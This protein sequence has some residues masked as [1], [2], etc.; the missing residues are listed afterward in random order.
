MTPDRIRPPSS[1][2]RFALGCALALSAGVGFGQEPP[3]GQSA[4]ETLTVPAREEETGRRPERRLETDRDSF[5]PSVPT[6]GRGRLILE[7]AYS[8]LDNRRGPETH[9]FPELLLRL[10]VAERIEL[11]LGWN[12]EIGG[13]GTWPEGAEDLPREQRITYGLKAAVTEQDRWVPES[14]VLL[15][16]FTPI[17]GESTATVFAV[18]YVLGWEVA[19]RWRFDSAVRYFTDSE[20]GDRF[21][22]WAP[23]AVLRVPVGERWNVHA[24][25]FGQFA[26]DRRENFARH[27]VS[28]G[29]SCLVT[30]D[31][32]LG[33]R[34]GWGLNDQSLRFFANAGLG[35]RY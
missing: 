29:V 24:E 22:V 2:T 3:P 20:E 32:E 25:Y 12:Y 13:A 26:T 7:S 8:F 27:F 1:T 16:A 30:P 10:G 18:G 14:S 23:S 15:D 19:D 28:P 9:S 5:T 4:T 33:V 21:G 34:V 17:E 6:A 11:R 31:L 35:W